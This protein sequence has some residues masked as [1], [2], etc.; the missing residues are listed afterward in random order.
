MSNT[1]VT[2]SCVLSQTARSHEG[3]QQLVDRAT[4]MGLYVRSKGKAT[5][6]FGLEQTRFEEL[7]GVPIR[8]RPAQPPSTG[9]YGVREGMDALDDLPIPKDLSPYIDSIAVEPPAIRMQGPLHS[10]ESTAPED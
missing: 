8:R 5:I 6:S 3:M 7:F 4:E 10:P 2:I 1:N 9:D